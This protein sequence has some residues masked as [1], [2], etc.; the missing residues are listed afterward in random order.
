MNGKKDAEMLMN[1]VL[2]VAERMLREYGEFYPYGGYME[3]SGG[4]VH[5]GAHDEDTDHPKSR[6]LLYVLRDSLAARARAKQCKATA[7]VFDVL[8]DVPETGRRSDAI[9]ICLEHADGYCAEVF[10]PYEIAATGRIIYGS[11]F[12]QQGK[13]EMFGD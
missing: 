10:I 6:D 12:A 7:I 3:A 13:H 11:T 4:I 1:A 8:V 5:V 9:Q 2:P